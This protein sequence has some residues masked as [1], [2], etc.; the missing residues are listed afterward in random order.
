MTLST[1]NYVAAAFS[2]I[3]VVALI[4]WAAGSRR[5]ANACRV[6]VLTW[7]REIGREPPDRPRPRGR[8]ADGLRE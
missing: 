1:V 4:W 2:S 5:F 8:D 3:G 7:C 6:A